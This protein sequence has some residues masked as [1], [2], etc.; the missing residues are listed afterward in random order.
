M[1]GR[2][3]TPEEGDLERAWDLSAPEGY[4]QS[5]NLAPSQLAPIVLP[6]DEGGRRIEAL[7]WGFQP[8]WAKR[9]WINARSETVFSSRAFAPAA[10]R[11]R[12]LVPALGWYEWQGKERPRQP[13][14]FHLDGFKPFAFAGIFTPGGDDAPPSFAIL[15]TEAPPPLAEIHGRMPVVLEDS[16]YD[17]WLASDCV[18]DEAQAIIGNNRVDM[19]VYK[20]SSYVNKPAN[21]DAACI[22]PLE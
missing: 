8:H 16:D 2:Y 15:T 18:E 7:I 11:N 3:L 10:R 19:A 22:R 20:V 4:H 17:R 9:G 13:W 12:C 1:C 21:N 14:L 5:Y 6:E